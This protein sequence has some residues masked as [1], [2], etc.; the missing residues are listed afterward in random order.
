MADRLCAL[1]YRVSGSPA[2]PPLIL[3]HA[4]GE[5]AADWDTVAADLGTRWRVYAVDLRGHGR[6]GR[7]GRYSVELMRDDVWAFADEL[8]L[9]RPVLVGHSLGAMVACLAAQ[10]HPDR[11]ARLVLE[12][13]P[14]LL[15]ADPPRAVPDPPD[16]QPAA[17]LSAVRAFLAGSGMVDR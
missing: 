11:V 17:F 10:R 15:P 13:P 4:L 1:A 5:S 7:P 8:G 2:A 16:G 14:P 12:E 3:L 6:S 9:D